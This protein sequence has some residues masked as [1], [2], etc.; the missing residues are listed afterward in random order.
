MLNRI[1]IIGNLGSDPEVRLTQDDR[2][3]LTFSVAT[4]YSFKPENGNWQKKTE[5]HK[6]AVFAE[7]L[8]V[9]LKSCLKK[10][11]KVFV[12]GRLTYS[13]WQDDFDQSHISSII[14]I[15]KREGEVEIICS[16][17]TDN[18]DHQ[19]DETDSQS[20]PYP[21]YQESPENLNN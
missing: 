18:Q 19:I 17:K 13:K 9:P 15:S 4:D 2:E 14:V 16:D 6:V 7:N 12:E 8:I 1:Q 20:S 5:W 3:F 10:G 21:I 11:K